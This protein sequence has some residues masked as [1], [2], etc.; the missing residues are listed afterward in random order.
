MAEGTHVVLVVEDD[1]G[2]RGMVS[3]HLQKRGYAIVEASSA[4]TAL[5]Q[6]RG[7]GLQYDVALTDVHLPGMS[8]VELTGLLLA[9][10]PLSPII[11][12]T[13]DDDARLARRALTEGATG[14]LLKPFELFELD[15]ALAQA[16][17]VLE[18]VETT[19][20]LARAQARYLD[21]WGEPGGSLPRFWLQLGDEK[22]GAG[23]GHGARVVSVALL[24]AKQLD[25]ALAATDRE[26]LRIA[27]RTHEIG[28]LLA[29]GEGRE[30]ATRSAQLL[31][32][33][34]FDD[35]VCDLVRLAAEPWSPGLP[36][37]AR[38][39]ALADWLDH[40]AVLR[41]REAQPDADPGDAIRDTVD[42]VLKAA[43]ESC[44]PDLARL[45]EENR[46]RVESMWVLQR[47]APPA[48]RPVQS[49]TYW[50]AEKL[51]APLPPS[52]SPSPSPLPG[53]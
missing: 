40:G 47:Q 43:G 8:G 18:L 17:S 51:T 28:R 27:A 38:V 44:D 42:A 46:E 23:E 6:I 48:G 16:V 1:P 10:S 5:T 50:P 4:E 53:A 29:G 2:I 11:V 36:L 19:K 34:A 15:A 39:L 14:Y 52:P 31:G 9:T 24:L 3:S 33:L 45:L 26:V 7:G 32:D 20:T 37:T 22:S 49:G 35:R 13:G 30:V 41:A 12:I 25:G 21:D